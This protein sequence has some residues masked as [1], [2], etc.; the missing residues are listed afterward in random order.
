[1]GC[2]V[3]ARHGAQ[4]GWCL[5][6][7]VFFLANVFAIEAPAWQAEIAR[8]RYGVPYIVAPTLADAAFGDGYAQAT[9]RAALLFD[10]ILLAT[11]TRAARL[12]AGGSG[13]TCLHG[14]GTAV[15]ANVC[16][17]L[18]SRRTGA[19]RTAYAR[20]PEL[21]P[22]VQVIAR[23][24]A[25]GVNQWLADHAAQA[26]ANARPIEPQEVIAL[27]QY[28]GVVRQLQQAQKEQQESGAD[29]ECGEGSNGW[30]LADARTAG[31]GP[32]IQVDPHTPWDGLNKWYEKAYVTPEVTVHGANATGAPLFLYAVTDRIAWTLTRNPGDRGDCFEITPNPNG[33]AEYR[34]DGGWRPFE[35]E[36]E[37]IEVAGGVAVDAK[38]LE[39]EGRPI[40]LRQ[41]GLLYAAGMSLYERVGVLGQLR[42]ML[43]ADD[44]GDFLAAISAMEIDG[45]NV[46]YTDVEGNIHYGWLNRLQNRNAGFDWIRCVPGDTSATAYTGVL[47]F[48]SL[49]ASTN[50]PGGYYQASNQA[51]WMREGGAWG[52]DPASFPDWMLTAKIGSTFGARPQRVVD[53]LESRA[54]IGIGRSRK[55]SIDR[56]ALTA[57][58]MI[59]VIERAVNELGNG[60]NPAVDDA[61]KELLRWQRRPI[62]RSGKRGYTL[63]HEWILFWTRDAVNASVDPSPPAARIREVYDLPDHPE[64]VSD[65]DL[66]RAHQAFLDA[67]ANLDAFHQAGVYTEPIPR[68][69]DINFLE[70]PDGSRV[71]FGGGDAETQTLWQGSHGRGTCGTPPKDPA[72]PSEDGSWVVVSGS[73]FMMAAQLRESKPRVYTLVPYGQSDDPA[74]PHFADQI[75]RYARGRYK[76]VPFGEP[77]VRRKAES[78]ELVQSTCQGLGGLTSY[79]RLSL[80][81]VAPGQ[82]FASC[83]SPDEGEVVC[84]LFKAR[85]EEAE[86]TPGPEDDP[87]L[88]EGLPGRNV[89]LSVRAASAERF[90]DGSPWIVFE[91][92]GPGR[93]YGPTFGGVK[94][95]HFLAGD[96]PK[97]QGG[98]G[99]DLIREYNDL[100]FVTVDVH[101]TCDFA[102]CES[103]YQGWIEKAGSNPGG[104]EGWYAD[105]AGLGYAA[106]GSRVLPI[107]EWAHA[108]AGERVCAHA[109]SGGSGRAIT[110][111]TRYAADDHLR[112]V[113]FDGGPVFAYIP[114]YCDLDQG[115]LGPQVPAFRIHACDRNGRDGDPT[116]DDC[117]NSNAAIYDCTR[118]PDNLADCSS[119]LCRDGVYDD[120]AM[121]A[122]SSFLRASRRS[123]PDIR[124]G[125]VL[126]GLDL[127]P[128]PAHAR[129][130]LSG[131]AFGSEVVPALSALEI[132]VRQGFCADTTGSYAIS[133][134]AADRRPCTD[135][136]PSNFPGVSAT[137]VGH[138]ARLASVGHNT[139]REA[140]GA[141]AVRDVMLSLCTP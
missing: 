110:A 67:V 95:G 2:E 106:M 78:V 112:A 80:V 91:S 114:W 121:L 68:W 116:N 15:G 70:L 49:P 26:P 28:A 84:G 109:H 55:F 22:E 52:I 27:L 136:D 124:L 65:L 9:D 115:P 89:L 16:A 53:Q 71:A 64:Q 3:G 50:D 23:A 38:I 34:F 111:L 40:F 11:G 118:S 7:V 130:W 36:T 61:L 81:E 132:E 46:L 119:R 120:A 138:D 82:R 105:T 79:G 125:V 30:V 1:M 18:A 25:A 24:F 35:V 66:A 127:S 141:A 12:G 10:N 94:P 32:I 131:Y 87:A 90:C 76:R 45:A 54:E 86:G 107:Y 135:W 63:F 6:W 21:P 31:R 33:S 123:F 104:G 5:G 113:V 117:E 96:A 48:F 47:P 17:D 29:P 129:L 41:N 77:E 74:S 39:A 62:A 57:E 58:W 126:G 83:Q 92:G 128:A 75:E 51:N 137:D 14:G 42:A 69:G 56:H 140:G 43:L 122:D 103:V 72:D 19:R 13:T 88:D 20:W 100:G 98:Y 101:W 4:H 102:N 37:R 73:D 139:T 44:L 108:Q 60:G 97:G 93:G 85:I 59:P 99:D 134:G 133:V 8:D